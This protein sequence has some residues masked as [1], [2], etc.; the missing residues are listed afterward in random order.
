MMSTTLPN[1][2]PGPKSD[3]CAEAC[4]GYGTQEACPPLIVIASTVQGMESA[5]QATPCVT[6]AILST[7]Q[8][9]PRS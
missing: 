8:K 1:S 5:A 2:L 9:E 3:P 7:G 6:A 4:S